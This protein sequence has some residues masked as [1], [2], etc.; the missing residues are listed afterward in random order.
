MILQCYSTCICYLSIFSLNKDHGCNYV[1]PSFCVV[2]CLIGRFI[3]TVL[4]IT[5]CY[6]LL[7][8]PNLNSNVNTYNLIL[9]HMTI[10]LILVA[11]EFSI[12]C[13]TLPTG[14]RFISPVY[15]FYKHSILS[16]RCCLTQVDYDP[17]FCMT[18]SPVTKSNIDDSSPSLDIS[19]K[20]FFR[21]SFP[22]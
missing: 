7:S 9:F 11:T 17:G 21:S 22:I 19:T 16:Y 3:P 12:A 8:G 14:L 1:L 20:P 10:I 15:L 4:L 18:I 13:R 5:P 6:A 2:F